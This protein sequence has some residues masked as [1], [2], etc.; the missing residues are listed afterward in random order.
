MLATLFTHDEYVEPITS[1][2]WR[3]IVSGVSSAIVSYGPIQMTMDDACQYVRALTTSSIQR[4]TFDP[5]AKTVSTRLTGSADVRTSISLFMETGGDVTE[6]RVDV[7]AF[8]GTVDIVS[9]LGSGSDTVAPVI[10]NVSA[11]PVDSSATV[12]WATDEPATSQ[13]EFGP[14]TAYGSSSALA[15]ALS[16]NHSVSLTG[17]TA[18]ALYH[19]RVL[20]RDASGNLATGADA[21]FTTGS[22]SLSVDDISVSEGNAGTVSAAFTVALSAPSALPVT[23]SFATADGTALGASDFSPATGTLTFAPGVRSL[24]VNVTVSGDTLYEADE[25][26]SLGL[27]SPTG[28]TLADAAGACEILNDDQ[29]PSL[30]IGDVTVAEGGTGTTT[31][32]F[33]VSL[34]VPSGLPVSVAYAT[35]GG[36]ATSDVDFTAVTGTLTFAP[37]DTSVTV[38]VPIVGDVLDETDETYAVGLSAVAGAALADGQGK[39]TILDDDPTPSLSIEDVAITE[40]DSGSSAVV[41]TV[42]L[43]APSGRA[44]SV[45]YATTDGTAKAGSDYAASSGTL[46][47][48][49]GVTTRTVSV[50]VLGDAVAEPTETFS[51]ALSQATNASLSRDQAVATITDN[52]ALPALSVNDISIQEGSGSGTAVFTIS[53]SAAS[54]LAVTVDYA[55]ADGTAASGSDYAATAGTLVFAPGVTTQTVSVTVLGDTRPESAETFTLGLSRAS[56]A[57]LARSSGTASI[58]DDDL[59]GIS[60]DDVSISE[61]NSGSLNAVFTVR[62]SPARSSA[63][64]VAYA[65][66]NGTAAAGSDYTAKT[67]TLTFTAGTTIRTLSVAVKG[68]TIDEADET[69]LVNLSSPV[70][71]TIV[72]GQAVGTIVDNDSAPSLTIADV[73]IIEGTGATVNALFA[74][75]CRLRVARRSA[76]S[77][78]P[79]T[80]PLPRGATTWRSQVP[81]RSHP[82]S[83]PRAS[84]SPSLATPRPSPTR[85]SS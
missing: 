1:A 47:F 77:T 66:A 10:S 85:R 32:V 20:S 80:A 78:P 50:A 44:V 52:D 43:S 31:A 14:T 81:S 16:A 17:L 84:V 18:N 33:T 25:T 56:G 64:T 72:D 51:L 4:S 8:T 79:P 46:T 76:L 34:S 62:L 21:T 11:T 70:N 35:V 15:S 23:V 24:K 6:S 38:G 26:Y 36:T 48:S 71:A 53:L 57:I 63:V 37:G 74:V 73:S 2:N 40:G 5:V 68:D 65:T 41:F 19:Y 27:S 12:A 22:P 55:T 54:A 59:S 67:G 30:S 39:G 45:A 3:S 7:P 75:S 28:A 58:I 61:G 13:V 69:L 42:G 82:G 83:P 9:P 29:Q 49:A 60:I